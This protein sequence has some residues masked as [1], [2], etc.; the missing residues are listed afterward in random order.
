MPKRKD[1]GDFL[2]NE[3]EELDRERDEKEKER[4]KKMAGVKEKMRIG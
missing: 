4:R 2:E 3:N 1:Q